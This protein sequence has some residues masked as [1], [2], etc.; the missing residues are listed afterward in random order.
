MLSQT[1]LRGSAS[2]GTRVTQPPAAGCT[3]TAASRREACGAATSSS[4]WVLVSHEGQVGLPPAAALAGSMGVAPAAPPTGKAHDQLPYC[5]IH[6]PYFR[7]KFNNPIAVD[8]SP[9]RKRLVAPAAGGPPHPDPHPQT[10]PKP[11]LR[12]PQTPVSGPTLAPRHQPGGTGIAPCRTSALGGGRGAAPTALGS[13]CP[14]PLSAP[15]RTTAQPGRVAPLATPL[16]GT[17]PAAHR[18]PAST[19]ACRPTASASVSQ[20][21]A[22][23]VCVK[24]GGGSEPSC[25][26]YSTTTTTTRTTR[27]HS[28]HAH[29]SRHPPHLHRG[30]RAGE[31]LGS[32]RQLHQRCPP[33]TAV[34]ASA[35]ATAAG[36]GGGGGGAGGSGGGGGG[37]GAAHAGQAG[38]GSYQLPTHWRDQMDKAPLGRKRVLQRW[39][40]GRV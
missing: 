21:A 27:T 5:C 35:A 12:T 22:T 4:I 7:H 32:C 40:H 3:A 10:N 38:G 8:S 17:L 24:C 16:L 33:R 2:A 26:P 39:V 34:A 36:A 20:S 14:A 31:P 9:H 15:T 28:T 29:V 25:S 19:P 1:L 11:C 37:G 6:L 18:C 13:S 30:S 23:S